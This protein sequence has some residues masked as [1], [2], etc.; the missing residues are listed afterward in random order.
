MSSEKALRSRTTPCCGAVGA[1]SKTGRTAR[2]QGQRALST[3][4]TVLPGPCL[5][6]SAPCPDPRSGAR[7]R[8]TH[9]RGPQSACFLSVLPILTCPIRL[10]PAEGSPGPWRPQHPMCLLGQLK[11]PLCGHSVRVLRVEPRVALGQ[12]VPGSASWAPWEGTRC[13][14]AR[15]QECA[16]MFLCVHSSQKGV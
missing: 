6:P 9:V 15:A 10:L 13:R 8:R 7:S 2:K 12:S 14:C 1:G 3:L 16:M 11:D 5:G 4:D